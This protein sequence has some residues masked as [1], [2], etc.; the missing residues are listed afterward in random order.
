MVD[1]RAATDDYPFEQRTVA[2]AESI[3]A[4]LEPLLKADQDVP[5][6]FRGRLT[7][8]VMWL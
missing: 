6:W 8:M 5:R 4:A 2:L 3:E 1:E 7:T